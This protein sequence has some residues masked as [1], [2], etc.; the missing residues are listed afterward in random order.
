MEIATYIY[1]YKIG[2][3]PFATFAMQQMKVEILDDT[4]PRV[5]IKF[6]GYHAD[7]R[8]P[9]TITKVEPRSL[10]RVNAASRSGKSATIEDYLST[11]DPDLIR[12][13]YKDD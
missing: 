4:G 6:H 3:Y 2:V 1:R 5:Q 13:P 12:K 11:L 9:G 7:G 10:K 8:G